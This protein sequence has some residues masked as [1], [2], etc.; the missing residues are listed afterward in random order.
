[1]TASKALME[2]R[3]ARR[4]RKNIARNQKRGI[5][6]AEGLE[7]LFAGI[8]FTSGLSWLLVAPMDAIDAA[9]ALFN[10]NMAAGNVIIERTQNIHGHFINQ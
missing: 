1:M 3:K 8:S 7:T 2:I 4:S 6:L 5:A 10:D 9:L